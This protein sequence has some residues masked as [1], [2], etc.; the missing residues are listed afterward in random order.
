M[1]TGQGED[2]E[3]HLCSHTFV[4]GRPWTLHGAKGRLVDSSSEVENTHGRW[5]RPE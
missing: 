5:V 1:N 4:C 3:P 2:R